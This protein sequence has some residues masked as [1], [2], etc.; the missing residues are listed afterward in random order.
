[1]EELNA[2]RG[3]TNVVPEFQNSIE[4]ANFYDVIKRI[5]DMVGALMGIILLSPILLILAAAIK[6][7][8][9]KGPVF[10]IHKRVGYKGKELPT[11]KFRS[12]VS[13]AEEVMKN[14]TSEQKKEYAENFKL[15]NDPRITK[16]GNFIRKTSMDEL[17]QLL[18]ILLGDMSIVGPRP[19]VTKE[20]EL[21]GEY[22]ELLL[23]V[24]PGLTGMW[25]AYGRSD[26]TYEERVKMDVEYITNRSLWLDIKII[27][28]TAVSV[29]KKQGAY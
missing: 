2:V 27:A 1:M 23:S 22:A 6:I 5:I 11:F 18:N 20:L 29:L 17:P 7:E 16:V 28:A 12:M 13:N 19:I 3:T 24:K 9:P 4:Q 26:T 8:D 21:Y 25:Q 15:K 10:F 14:F